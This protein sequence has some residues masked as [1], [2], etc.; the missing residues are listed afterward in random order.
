[1]PAIT[2]LTLLSMEL[3]HG[4]VLYSVEM[5]RRQHYRSLLAINNDNTECWSVRV[6]WSEGDR[7]H[8]DNT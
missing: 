7:L 6:G 5:I 1:M 2:E 3:T 8:K 4:K